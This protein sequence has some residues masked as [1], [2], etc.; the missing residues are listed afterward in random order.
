MCVWGGNNQVLPQHNEMLGNNS[1]FFFSGVKPDNH[2]KGN[3]PRV[4]KSALP[5]ICWPI[6]TR[7]LQEILHHLSVYCSIASLQ[8]LCNGT[9]SSE[10]QNKTNTRI[11]LC[12]DVNKVCRQ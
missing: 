1:D 10:K 9:S 7:Y 11:D 2:P 3:F 12:C 5:A 8:T 6:K 4:N